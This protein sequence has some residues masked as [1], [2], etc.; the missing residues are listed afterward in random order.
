M[1]VTS[2]TWEWLADDSS[3][4]VDPVSPVFTSRFDAEVWL[5]QVWRK[6]AADGVVAARLVRGDAR[7]V[8]SA[9]V[10]LTVSAAAGSPARG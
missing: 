4:V 8:P 9:T 2:W 7:R 10:T 5:G 1:T 6:R 3:A